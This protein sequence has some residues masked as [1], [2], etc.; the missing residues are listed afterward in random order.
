MN[1]RPVRL[2]DAEST[3]RLLNAIIATGTETSMSDPLT[4]QEQSL[5]I[6]SFPSRG[7]FLVA[8]L[9]APHGIVGMQ[10]IEPCGDEGGPTGHVAEISTFVAAAYRGR[11]VASAL[12]QELVRRAR[13][14]GICKLSAT[15][16][17]DNPSAQAFYLSKAGFR[18]VG[19]MRSQLFYR[20]RS[21]NRAL[22]PEAH[23]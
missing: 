14:N 7:V 15:I 11:G 5:C 23:A 2:D 19:T 3:A 8:E 4:P 6:T 21:M 13:A 22:E 12:L 18:L 1:L 16:R 17:A 20:K 10:S 9:P